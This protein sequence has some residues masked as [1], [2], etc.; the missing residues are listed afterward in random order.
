M[1]KWLV[2]YVDGKVESFA[3]EGAGIQILSPQHP[4]LVV[5]R[6]L[7]QPPVFLNLNRVAKWYQEGGPTLATAPGLLRP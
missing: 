4:I 1:Q 3:C 7:Q 2:E 6:T 5:N